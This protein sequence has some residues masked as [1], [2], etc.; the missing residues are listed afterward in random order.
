MHTP[1][2]LGSRELF[3]SLAHRIYAN[4]ASVSPLSL[5]AIDAMMAVMNGQATEGVAAMFGFHEDVETTRAVAGELMGVAPD[6]I[7]MVAS[8]STAISAVAASI[9]WK[10]GETIVV[11]RGE[12][13]A[14]TTPWQQ[15]AQRH[16]L[17]IVWLEA[18]D[19]RT[20]R[21]LES[22][23]DALQN[24]TVRLVAVSAVQF[25]T[26]LRMPVEAMAVAAHTHG[27]AIFVDAIQAMGATP[28]DATHLDY[29]ATGGQ[30]WLMGPPGTGLLYARDWSSLEPT[31]A[32]WLS[33]EDAL[34]FL[35][36]DEDCMDYDRPLQTGPAIL[37]GGTLNFAGLAGLTAAMKL[38]QSIGVPVIHAHANAWIDR[39]EPGLCELGFRSMRS[40]DPAQRSTLLCVRPPPGMHAGAINEGLKAAGI[41][42]AT[43]DAHLRFSPSWPNGLDEPE[44]ILE[45]LRGLL[46]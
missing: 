34:T 44:L 24:H 35:W 29:I 1:P 16:Q 26:G 17:N 4:H 38:I 37:E 39:L 10:P 3:P 7:A 25:S 13:P 32:G 23:E 19:F 45:T 20:E 8:T 46:S 11:F 5:P 28:I 30:K 6:R 14:N 2:S 42:V 43:P 41:S 27:A 9:D 40:A 21:G 31:L 15:A 22:L 12:F 33:H 36:G 18:D